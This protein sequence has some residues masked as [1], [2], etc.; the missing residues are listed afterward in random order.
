[1]PTAICT[2]CVFCFHDIKNRMAPTVW[3]NWVCTHKSVERKPMINP[4]T[5]EH[6]Y[7]DSNDLGGVF[8]TTEPYP[9]C[10][11]INVRGECQKYEEK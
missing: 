11:D 8:T 3:Y 2:N 5:G 9:F 1:M 10:R 4:V 6:E 7:E